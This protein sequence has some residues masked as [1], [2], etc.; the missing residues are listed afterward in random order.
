MQHPPR[1][2][3]CGRIVFLALHGLE[4]PSTSI[5]CR[6][7]GGAGVQAALAVFHTVQLFQHAMGNNEVD[8]RV[9]VQG[10]SPQ[11]VK[12]RP[13]EREEAEQH[14]AGSTRP[15]TYQAP[16]PCCGA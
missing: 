15:R 12:E 4:Q 16:T 11:H 14:I 6:S 10:S 2:V 1:R 7:T 9:A 13:E 5:P 3:V 8:R